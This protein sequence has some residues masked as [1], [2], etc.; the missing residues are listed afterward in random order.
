MRDLAGPTGLFQG[1][2][3]PRA[4]VEALTTRLTR[5][6]PQATA[7]AGRLPTGLWG[8]RLTLPEYGLFSMQVILVPYPDRVRITV[9]TGAWGMGPPA[10]EAQYLVLMVIARRLLRLAQQE[11]ASPVELIVPPTIFRESADE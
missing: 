3:Q 1:M 9:W 8:V 4:W 7:T 5:S 11:D 6:T 10:R 2:P